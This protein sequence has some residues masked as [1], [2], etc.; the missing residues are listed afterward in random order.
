[1]FEWIQR[2]SIRWKL[3]LGFFIVTMVTTV[4]NRVLAT[5]E[6]SKMI[7]IA[8]EGGVRMEL[9]K[10]L[11][12]DRANYIFNSFWESGIE[13]ALQFIIIGLLANLFVRPIQQLCEAL[14][15][16]EK[17]DLTHSVTRTSKDEIGHLQQSFETMR[18]RLTTILKRIEDSGKQVHQSAYQVATIARDIAEVG[19][20]EERRSAEVSSA[21]KALLSISHQVHDN[22]QKAAECTR[23]LEA[24]GREGIGTVER[25]IR[26]MDETAAQVSHASGS[27]GELEKATSQ[28]HTIIST[29]K[30]IAGQTNLLALN[31]A[32]EAAR[33]GESGRGFAVV[34]DE[35]R[36][37]AERST[38]SAD[39]VADI[40]G[41]LN[42]QVGQVTSSM[43][44][45][46]DRVHASRHVADETVNV[47]TQMVREIS[48]TVDAN[49]SISALSQ[50]QMNEF[51]SLEER[52]DAL[53]M[54]LRESSSK[55]ETTAT[56]GDNI[57]QVSQQL[58]EMM[59]DFV[60]EREVIIQANPDEKRS[61]PRADNNLLV[62][63]RHQDVIHEGVTVDI[64]LSGLNVLTSAKLQKGMNIPVE[65]FL[66]SSD[67]STFREQ[68][69]LSVT[70]R[71]AWA[72][73]DGDRMQYGF[74]FGTL[75]SSQEQTL[76]DC[77]AYF[78]QPAE[79]RRS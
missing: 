63:L 13:F 5:H 60:L 50:N 56:I 61:F 64:S 25:N 38:H 15:A 36:K 22:T 16:L 24:R 52:L 8:R 58:T 11:E 39:Q 62:R 78:N 59:A 67:I 68:T 54:T 26:E 18:H 17:G 34:A 57:F 9:L 49:R 69:P 44:S 47:I 66:P 12:G 65:I 14:Q 53:F 20:A 74:D 37:L 41:Q 55:V 30:E 1:M 42:Q 19:R 43:S 45:V 2:L 70:G 72:R 77:L 10:Q 71:V 32:I 4:Y 46:V 23:Q 3:Q 28:I 33:A 31:A 27:I 29:I 51:S 7:E 79:F 6:L 73:V 48:S 35:V 76:R 75:N 21:T 40:I